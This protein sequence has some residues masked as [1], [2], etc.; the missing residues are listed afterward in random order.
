MIRRLYPFYFAIFPILA[1]YAANRKELSLNVVF[2]P[3]VIAVLATAAMLLVLNLIFKAKD[4]VAAAVS[5][6][7][8]YFFSYQS[9]AGISRTP[10][11]YSLIFALLMIFVL[12]LREKAKVATVLTIL[13]LYL[14]VY[15][16]SQVVPYELKRILTKPE[17]ILTRLTAADPLKKSQLPDIYYFIFDRYAAFSTLS[18]YYNFDNKDFFNFLKSQGF[19]VATESAAN[20]PRTHL[21][22]ASSLNLDYLDDL[23]RQVGRD[24][25]DYTPIFDQVRHNQVANFLKKQGYYYIYAGDWWEPTR[26]SK[27]ADININLY[28]SS[29]EFLRK[30]LRTT[31]VRPLIGDYYKGNQ[32]FGFFQDRI[33]ENTNYKLKKLNQIVNK[34]SPKFIF[35]HMLFPHHPYLFD[36]DCRRADGERNMP[37][38]KK[39]LEQ[40][41]CVNSKIKELIT[42]IFSQSKKP[43]IIIIQSDEGPYK[44]TEMG[45]DGEKADWRKVSSE[46]VKTHMKILNAYFLPGFDYGK[47]YPSITPV[48]SFRLIF[49][50][51]FG[52]QLPLLPDK[53]YFIPNI[54]RP[55]DY[56]D[57]TDRL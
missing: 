26:V 20:Y 43:P 3:L 13:G 57:I 39:Y 2:A 32:L 47:L 34:K 25:S 52:T 1:F 55:Y 10:L 21:S 11:V 53:N 29:S 56:T 19:Y 8:L 46:A 16:L 42:T 45:L 49:N 38:K 28:A 14:V 24:A 48:N 44:V 15:N 9:L 22:L 33:Y 31:I 50:H 18:D 35:A 36:K 4:S 41:V 30:F 23:A 5:I 54:D 40:L 27:Q 17:M 12:R 37:E 51:Y 6:F 7:L